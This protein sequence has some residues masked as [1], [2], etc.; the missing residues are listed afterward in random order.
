MLDH[1]LH[2]QN[3]KVLDLYAGS[4]ALGI[5]SLSR[6]AQDACFV[7]SSKQH[8]RILKKNLQSLNIS[9]ELYNIFINRAEKWILSYLDSRYPSLVFLDPPY[10]ENHYRPMLKQISES[11]GII[12]GS[13]IVVESPKTMVFQFPQNLKMIIRKNYGGT[14]LQ[15][16]EKHG[17]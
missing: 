15:I 16:L 7:E 14:A 6:G 12:N 10:Q 17:F 3:F 9:N 2:W 11:V 1:R 8:A 4:G 5:E 13:I